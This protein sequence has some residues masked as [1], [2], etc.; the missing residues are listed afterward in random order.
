MTKKT[1]FGIKTARI[2]KSATQIISN[3]EKKFTLKM[4]FLIENI[5]SKKNVN[6]YNN[7]LRLCICIQVFHFIYLSSLYLDAYFMF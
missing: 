4:R 5:I 3:G 2:N 6:V 1:H 7:E